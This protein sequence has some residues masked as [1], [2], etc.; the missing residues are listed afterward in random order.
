MKFKINDTVKIIS[1]NK[2]SN[3]DLIGS[4]TDGLRIG[5]LK[6][7]GI[8]LTSKIIRI[9]DGYRFPYLLENGL[10]MDDDCLE[11]VENK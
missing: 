2:E 7:H 11:L 10:W 4:G 8:P 9:K 1:K 6:G 3:Y 5:I